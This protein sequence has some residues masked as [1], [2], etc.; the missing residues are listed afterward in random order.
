MF[1]IKKQLQRNLNARNY[2]FFNEFRCFKIYYILNFSNIKETTFAK[3]FTLKSESVKMKIFPL[4]FLW[5]VVVSSTPAQH[6]KDTRA[7]AIAEQRSHLNTEPNMVGNL[8]VDRGILGIVAQ[9][10]LEGLNNHYNH[11]NNNNH[12]DH[13]HRSE[14]SAEET[15]KESSEEE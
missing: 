12:Y 14:E 13:H 11:N 6:V 4:L 8:E 3:T 15:S 5:I 7:S 2:Q 10:I 9:G 1:S